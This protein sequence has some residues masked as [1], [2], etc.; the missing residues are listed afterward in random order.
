MKIKISLGQIAIDFG[1]PDKNEDKIVDF[2]AEAARQGSD[3]ILFPEL[4]ST[5]YDLNNSGK[6]ANEL[7][8]GIFF[9]CA[10]VASKYHIHLGGSLLEKDGS[11]V[12]NTFV[13][14]NPIGSVL[15]VYRKIHL[16]RPMDEDK[17]LCAGD[18]LVIADTAWGRAGLSICYDL[19]FPEVFRYFALNGAILA[20]I[21]A[22]WPAVRLEH[23]RTLLRARA[24]ENQIFVVATNCTGDSPTEKF[25]GFSAI[26]DPWGNTLLETNQD[27]GLFSAVIDLDDV[28]R[29]RSRIPIIKD[30]R[31][32]IYGE[33]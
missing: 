27:E 30:R 6:N 11:N 12:Y 20:L 29:I 25:G 23:W 2:T 22:E 3:L 13:L 16:F 5:G 14:Y 4:W 19:R 17:W 7:N 24:I 21:P 33:F 9:R 18:R 10:S 31:P 32:D 28:Y 8:D 26:I 1:R 15:G